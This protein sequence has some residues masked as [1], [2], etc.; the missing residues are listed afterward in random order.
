VRR[1]IGEVQRL[2]FSK[3]LRFILRFLYLWVAYFSGDTRNEELAKLVY[4]QREQAS[5][6][7]IINRNGEPLINSTFAQK[8]SCLRALEK[9]HTLKKIDLHIHTLP[10]IS[11]SKFT[12]CMETLIEYVEKLEIDC[13]AITNHNLFDKDQ[14]QLICQSVSIKVQISFNTTL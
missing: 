11:D 14:F 8:S 12:F 3:T 7:L 2:F 1:E 6:S 13:I 9:F 10:S 4:L 5:K